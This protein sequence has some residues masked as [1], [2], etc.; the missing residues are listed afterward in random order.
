MGCVS[1]GP[2]ANSSLLSGTDTTGNKIY[3]SGTKDQILRSLKNYSKTY[4][5]ST[6]EGKIDYLLNRLRT[7]KFKLERNGSPY[8]PDEAVQFLRWKIGRPRWQGKVNSAEDFV[9][10]ICSGSVTSGKPY[11]VILEDGNRHDMKFLFQNE[12]DLLTESQSDLNSS[13]S[14]KTELAP[15]TSAP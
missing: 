5:I 13:S 4:D 10:V 1:S 9:T 3:F 8:S 2:H 11:V 12:L 14:P 6:L 7:T 15:T